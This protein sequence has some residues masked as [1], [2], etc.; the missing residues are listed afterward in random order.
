MKKILD[1][2]IKLLVLSGLFLIIIA[3]VIMIFYSPELGAKFGVL[4][5]C[6]LLLAGF[7]N[8]GQE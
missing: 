6:M 1:C 8:L 3:M 5:L 4:G 2:L 7:M